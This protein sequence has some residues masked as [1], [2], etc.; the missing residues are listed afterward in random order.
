MSGEKIVMID[1]I[2]MIDKSLGGRQQ[3]ISSWLTVH[4]CHFFALT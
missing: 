2:D 3:I 1:L 4:A